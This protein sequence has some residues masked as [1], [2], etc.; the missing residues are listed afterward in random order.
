MRGTGEDINNWYLGKR[1]RGWMM[2]RKSQWWKKEHGK[3][4]FAFVCV[5]VWQ[6]LI[7]NSGNRVCKNIRDRHSLIKVTRSSS[8]RLGG[9]EA[10]GIG[11]SNDESWRWRCAE[12]PKMVEIN[13]EMVAQRING[14][15]KKKSLDAKESR[16]LLKKINQLRVHWCIANSARVWQ[17]PTAPVWTGC[18]IWAGWLIWPFML[19]QTKPTAGLWVFFLLEKERIVTCSSIKRKKKSTEWQTN[20]NQRKCKSKN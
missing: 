17:H 11:R 5:C 4:I 10:F 18:T 7:C 20:R 2:H 12:S 15:R 9:R 13:L 8:A 1:G 14:V 19:E 16:T 6:I 3:C